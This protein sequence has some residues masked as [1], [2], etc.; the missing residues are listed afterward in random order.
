MKELILKELKSF[1]LTKNGLLEGYSIINEVGDLKNIN[2]YSYEL[3]SMGG[4]FEFNHNNKTHI[5]KVV[6]FKVSEEYKLM[7][8]F[9]PASN[10]E[11]DN[12]Y[13]IQYDIDDNDI[14]LI[15]SNYKLLI[16]ILKT[17]SEIVNKTIPKLGEKPILLLMTRDNENNDDIRKLNLYN[18]II[19]KN[20]P[21]GFK[22]TTGSVKEYGYNFSVIYKQ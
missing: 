3:N 8:K 4:E 2:P 14:Q 1:T 15:K 5:V 12:I 21:N 20:I 6:L 11:G 22:Q 18:T 9:A 10:I 13:N 16:K 17:V 7:L 19:S